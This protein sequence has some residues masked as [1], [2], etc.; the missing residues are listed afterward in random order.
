[1][2]LLSAG[3]A[4]TD[5][6]VKIFDNQNAELP[7]HEMG[8]IVVRGDVVMRGYWNDP[9]STSETLEDGW[10]HTGDIGYM[11]E[12]G[13]IFIMDRK[14][15]MIISGGSNIYPREVEEVML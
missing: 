7:P 8:E 2:R 6:E 4:R 5:V 11:D 10:L 14:K 3:R 12:R 13:Y 9:E 15:D 1:M